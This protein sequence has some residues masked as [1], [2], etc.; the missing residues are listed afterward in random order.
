MQYRP[1]NW[2]TYGSPGSVEA[3]S[4][5]RRKN[6]SLLK[7]NQIIAYHVMDSTQWMIYAAP[8]NEPQSL[9]TGLVK[10]DLSAGT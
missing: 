9:A 5:R 8:G 1:I 3:R 2:R 7:A 4:H 10:V 6:P